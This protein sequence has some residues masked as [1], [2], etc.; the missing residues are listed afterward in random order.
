MKQK[1]LTKFLQEN[2]P[3]SLASSFDLGKIGLQFGSEDKEISKV[4]ITLDATNDVIDEALENKCD[5]IISHH[6][7]MFNPMLSINYYSIYGKKIL[8]VLDNRLNLY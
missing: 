2:Y 1:E 5:L 6:P 3:E 7:F 8:K 4:M